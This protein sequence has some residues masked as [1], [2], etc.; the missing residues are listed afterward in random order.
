MPG[1]AAEILDDSVRQV[2]CPRK[3]RTEQW[4][5]VITTAHEE[6][7]PTSATMMYGHIE[8]PWQMATHLE[9]IRNIQK[10]TGGFTEFVPLSF[11]HN[12]TPLYQ[13]GLCGS[14][15]SGIMDLKVHAIARI[16]LNG[17]INNIQV[18]W[19]KLGRR[20]AQVCLA[21]GANDVGGTLMEENI[22]RMAGSTSPAGLNV[23]ELQDIITACGRIPAQRSTTYQI[24]D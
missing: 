11:V 23:Q 12:N 7:I 9:I 16:M 14:G 4:V 19:V 1:T 20:L 24:L 13:R 21:A 22:S 8:Q 2:I 18:S 15:A 10:A 5:E 6:G 17:L 3:L